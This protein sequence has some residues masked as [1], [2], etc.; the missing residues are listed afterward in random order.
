MDGN[1]DDDDCGNDDAPTRNAKGMWQGFKDAIVMIF[2]ALWHVAAVHSLDAK[3]QSE[4]HI[5]QLALACP[6]MD[7]RVR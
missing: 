5:K 3:R 2:R 6:E 1:E 7:T 4:I